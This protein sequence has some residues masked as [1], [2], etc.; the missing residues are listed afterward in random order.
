MVGLSSDKEPQIIIEYMAVCVYHLKEAGRT[1]LVS[2]VH[3]NPEAK[4][5]IILCTCF[6]PEVLPP[7]ADLRPRPSMHTHKRDK[8]DLRSDHPVQYE[9][10]TKP[11]TN[12]R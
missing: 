4:F 1:G 12:L 6:L 11:Q 9:P 5:L 3:D 2:F 7:E 10:S 8:E